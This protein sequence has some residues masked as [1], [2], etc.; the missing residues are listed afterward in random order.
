MKLKLS[1]KVSL[2]IHKRK[3]ELKIKVIA[4]LKV[5]GSFVMRVKYFVVEEFPT[6]AANASPIEKTRKLKLIMYLLTFQKSKV[7]IRNES[8]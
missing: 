6:R 4:P 5:F 7:Q 3:K 1:H 8:G 2:T